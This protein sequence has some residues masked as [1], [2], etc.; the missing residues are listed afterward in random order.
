M[1]YIPY[2]IL[3]ISYIIYKLIQNYQLQKFAK[4]NGCKQPIKLP[5][6]TILS[7]LGLE[8]IINSKKNEKEGLG[9]EKIYQGLQSLNTSTFETIIFFKKFIMTIE[10]ENLRCMMS[11]ANFNDWNIG[12]RPK[13]FGIL[14]GNSI[15]SSEGGHWKDSR[16]L[17]RPFF[18]KDHIKHITNMEPFVDRVIKLIKKTN[19]KT[20]INL[21]DIFQDFTMDYTTYLLLGESSDSLKERLGEPIKE[22]ISEKTRSQ[23]TWAFDTLAP[24]LMMRALLGH[25]MFLYNPTNMQKCIDIQHEFV[26]Y[27]VQK[28]LKMSSEELDK[29]SEGGT[30]F[31]Y[32]LAKHT[33]DPIVLRDNILSIILAGRNTTSGL[34][35]F[36]FMELSR[37]PD[38]FNKL[39]EIIRSTFPDLQSITYESTQNCDYLRW[40]I[41][42]TLRVHPSVPNESKTAS[43]NVIL[44]KGGGPDNQSPILIKKGQQ[45]LYPLWSSNRNPKYFGPEPLIFKPERW[46]HLPRNGGIAFFPFSIGPRAC[47]GQQLALI[48]A[49]YITIRL[50]QTFNN[51]EWCGNSKDEP[52]RKSVSATMRLL[53]GCNVIMS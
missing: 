18:A 51:L 19:G 1:N 6:P 44:P 41:N 40:C 8:M 36:L 29:K 16:T 31:L 48:E 34:M 4:K 47:L 39:K 37:N 45:V 30:L 33:K 7:K 23:F 35:T 24:K 49:S 15:F 50:L 11:S 9:N 27:Y 32:E 10:P 53:D 17:L 5:T 42:E 52:L 28:A 12:F 38:I 3:L 25:F 43:K 13:A 46:A 20:I 2:L 14:L 26:D 21:Q 22:T